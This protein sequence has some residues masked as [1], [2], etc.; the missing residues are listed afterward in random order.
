M[1][2]GLHHL[3]TSVNKGAGREFQAR[4][5]DTFQLHKNLSKDLKDPCR[6]SQTF[7]DVL[8]YIISVNVPLIAILQKNESKCF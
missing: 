1:L 8:D 4:I 2:L 3:E 6:N 5:A 7:V